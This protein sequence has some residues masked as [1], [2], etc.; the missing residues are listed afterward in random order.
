M[1]K[2]Y[3]IVTIAL[4]F[5]V[6]AKAES[7]PL[8]LSFFNL[9]NTDSIIIN[10]LRN[11]NL[12]LYINKPIDSLL[13]AIPFAV[14]RYV[15]LNSKKCE[16]RD[17]YITYSDKIQIGVWAKSYQFIN[18]VDCSRRYNSTLFT[19]ELLAYV[20]IEYDHKTV[21]FAFE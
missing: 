17:T 3:V 16:I 4:F 12:N 14:Q 18:P 8:Q 2:K 5:T 11:L 13:A 20:I 7:R 6:F 1:K 10:Y 9:P 19:K 21:N 15:F